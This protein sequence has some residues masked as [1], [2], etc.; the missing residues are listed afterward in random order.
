MTWTNRA[1]R[2][3]PTVVA[4][5]LVACSGGEATDE[6]P[7]GVVEGSVPVAPGT[8][9]APT[10][11]SP[12]ST[13]GDC[14]NE[15]ATATDP[16][17]RAG[18]SV[19]ADID[20]DGNLDTVAL[21]LDPAGTP[22]CSAFVVVDLGIEVVAAPVWEMGSEGGLPQP[23][24]HGLEDI[25]DRPGDEILVDEAAGASTQF[26]GAFTFIEGDLTRITARGGIGQD[27]VAAFD[28]LFPYGGSV[29]HIEGVDCAGGFVVV[30]TATPS[31]D[32]DEL[33]RGI[34]EVA[35]RFFTL[36]EGTLESEETQRTKT[37]AV[38]L[39]RFPE[40]GSAP[41]ANC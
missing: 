14:P 31:S 1:S 15:A 4:A 9:S 24:I 12:V 26:L 6:L 8:A 23:R 22:G 19:Q 25:D 5:V 33:A 30:S 11:P 32:Q 28:N 18:T 17:R 16:A 35:R 38:E 40:F 29:G 2:W 37:T 7:P 21:A 3:F 27:E 13:A 34:Y 36:E 20:G 39:D 10:S 41:F